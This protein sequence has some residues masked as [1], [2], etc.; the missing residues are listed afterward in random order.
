M[1]P[2]WSALTD[3]GVLGDATKATADK[4]EQFL[5]AAVEGLVDLVRELKANEIPERRDRH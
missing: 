3:S 5:E 1:M 2:Y 4:G